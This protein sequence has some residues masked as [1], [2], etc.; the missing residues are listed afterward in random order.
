M[1]ANP[2]ETAFPA[3][4]NTLHR[5]ELADLPTPLEPTEKLA[6]ELG[7]DNLR[8]K[9]DD[10]TGLLY[11]GNKVRKLEYLFGEA[12]H[13]ECD[14]VI[15]FGAVG[16]NHALAT[17]IYAT[18]LDLNCHVVMTE[19][20]GTPYVDRTLRY[21]AVLGTRLELAQGFAQLLEIA[22]RIA[23]GHPTGADRLY[24]IPFGG[25][26]PLGTVGFVNAALELSTQCDDKGDDKGGDKAPDVIYVASGTMGTVAG[27]ALGLRLAGL[28]T[29]VEAV[30]VVPESVMMLSGIEKLFMEANRELQSIDRSIPIFADPLINVAVRDEFFGAGY[31]EATPECLEAV[32]LIHDTES[33]TLETTYT[34]KALAALIHDARSGK[35]SGQSV[36][37]WNTYNARPYPPAVNDETGSSLPDWAQRYLSHHD[38]H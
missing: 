33:V 15:T 3:L 24:R 16:S 11:G 25:S 5:V 35:L 22:D 20:T 28:K 18:R 14:S 4:R 10:Q 29:R 31:A 9:R 7:L 21:H 30:R 12:L 23:A 36:V 8:I 13:R 6:A 2:L 27:L 1:K 38:H 19:Q 34:G 37:F 26:S 32:S 17:A